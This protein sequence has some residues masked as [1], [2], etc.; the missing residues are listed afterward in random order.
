MIRNVLVAI[1]FLAGI[2]G[3]VISMLNLKTNTVY[4]DMGK[5]YENFGLSKEL[6]KALDAQIKHDKVITDS[7][8]V[9]LRNKTK[10][11]KDKPK[12]TEEDINFLARLEEDFYYNQKKMENEVQRISKDN[13][14]KIWNQLNQYIQDFGKENKYTFILGA[15]GQGTIM[16]AD[17][18]KDVTNTITQYVNDRY[19]GIINK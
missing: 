12:K 1:A 9:N 7:L 16:Y 6:N 17:D 19:N 14:A 2:S 18:E 8:Y 4:I 15:N 5:I 10:E 13:D 11:V 3:F